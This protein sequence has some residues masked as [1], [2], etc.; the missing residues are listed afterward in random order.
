MRINTD[1]NFGEKEWEIL[2]TYDETMIEKLCHAER[3]SG[4]NGFS[5]DRSRRTIARIPRHRL[6]SDIELL[7]WQQLRGKDNKEADRQLNLWL[8][9]NPQFKTCTGGI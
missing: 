3:M 8:F 4:Q 9:K 2:H 1:V 5:E 7:R 6:F